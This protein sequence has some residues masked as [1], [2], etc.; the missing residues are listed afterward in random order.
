MTCAVQMVQGSPF[1]R[2]NPKKI[3]TNRASS[4]KE[5]E[6]KKKQTPVLPEAA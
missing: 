4:K 6:K 1:Y 2:L 5:K 3:N